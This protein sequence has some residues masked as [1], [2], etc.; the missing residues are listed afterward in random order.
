MVFQQFARFLIGDVNDA[1]NFG[2]ELGCGVVAVVAPAGDRVTQEG[3]F[4]IVTI[5]DHADRVAHAKHLDHT[6]GDLRN[7]LNVIGGAGSDIVKDDLFGY[8]PSQ[9]NANEGFQLLTRLVQ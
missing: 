1:L 9:A 3:L 2:I 4:R 8:A 5:V 7:L 6:A